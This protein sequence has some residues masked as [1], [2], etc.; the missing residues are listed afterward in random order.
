MNLLEAIAIIAA[1]FAAGASYIWRKYTDFNW[2]DRV[3]ITSADWVATTFTPAA[4]ACPGADGQRIAAANC[5]TITYYQPAFQ[6]PT[7]QMLTN[8][9]DYNRVFNGIEVTARKRMSHHWLM[10][11]S[12]AYNDTKMRCFSVRRLSGAGCANGGDVPIL[13]TPRAVEDYVRLGYVPHEKNAA[14]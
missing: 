1:G 7:T 10:N 6:Q 8:I 9:P 5:P 2:N 14:C 11:T 3:G 4:S 12:Y 13:P